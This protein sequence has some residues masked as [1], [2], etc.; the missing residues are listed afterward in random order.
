MSPV[1]NEMTDFVRFKSPLDVKL[2]DNS[3]LHGYGKGT[4]HLSVFDGLEKINVMLEDVLYVPKIQNKLLSLPS[5]TNKGAEV[6]FKGQ[7]CKVIINDKVYSIGH[8]HGKLYKLNSEPEASCCFGSTDVKDNSLSIWHLCFGH[9]GYDNLKLLD[10]KSLV[11]SLSSDQKEAFDGQC[12]G[13]AFG[14]QHRNPF[15]KKSEHE[16]SQLLELIHIL[17]SVDQCL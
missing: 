14:K 7:S 10:N 13:C 6:Q 2:A 11:V 12:E 3:V 4:V 16:S 5:V 1:K 17:M 9:L 8:K 15:P